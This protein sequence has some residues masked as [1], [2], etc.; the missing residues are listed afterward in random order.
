M[1][2]NLPS[3][4]L[5]ALVTFIAATREKLPFRYEGLL[6]EGLGVYCVRRHLPGGVTLYQAGGKYRIRLNFTISKAGIVV[7]KYDPGDWEE[8]IAESFDRACRLVK[9]LGLA[10]S[11]EG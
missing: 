11:A 8:K 5:I 10:E 7:T 6:S 9:E 2:D 4:A 1:G 3:E